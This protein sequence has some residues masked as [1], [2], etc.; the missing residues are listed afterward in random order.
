MAF[1]AYSV[2]GKYSVVEESPRSAAAKFYK[3]FPKARK[4]NIVEGTNDGVFFTVTYG[5][6]SNGEWPRFY[7]NV[8]RKEIDNLPI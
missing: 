4:C 7:K 2:C 6:L 3:L 5:R 1:R 8:T